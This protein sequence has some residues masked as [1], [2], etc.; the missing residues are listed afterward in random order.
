MRI[1][2]IVLLVSAVAYCN[3]TDSLAD[4]QTFVAEFYNTC[5]PTTDTPTAI[6]DVATETITCSD[7]GQCAGTTSGTDCSWDRKLCLY[8]Y[9]DSSDT[10]YIRVLSNGLPNHCYSSPMDTPIELDVDFSV[11]FNWIPTD[12]NIVFNSS[13]EFTS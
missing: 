7:V 6:A 13:D 12:T 10:T 1:L 2:T 9:Q 3:Y 8:C 5:D 4:C 11:K